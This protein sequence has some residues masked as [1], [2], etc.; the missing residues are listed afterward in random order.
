MKQMIKHTLT[1]FCAGILLALAAC[2][3]DTNQAANIAA[4]IADFDLPSGYMADFSAAVSGYSVVAYNPGDDH[5]HLYLIQS[6]Q[7]ADGAALEKG[8][9]E[10][11]PGARDTNSRMTVIE[12]RPV[13]VRGQAVTAVITEGTNSEN[14]QY[15]QLM[16]AFQGKGGPA[17]LA[18]STPVEAWDE[19]MV[20][21]LLTSIR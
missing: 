15:R 21:A 1:L 6:S 2:T 8:L 11:I 19:A 4:D 7:A 3:P 20:D 10:L 17:L 12:N 18:L 14:D 9:A 16:V 13:T 5:S